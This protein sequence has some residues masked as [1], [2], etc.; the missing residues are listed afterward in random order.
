MGNHFKKIVNNKILQHIIFWITIVVFLSIPY[1]TKAGQC[2]Q[3]S[4]EIL[5]LTPAQI[6]FVYVLIYLLIP[7]FLIKKKYVLFFVSFILT[8]AAALMI[9]RMIQFYITS[10]IFYADTKDG[11]EFW[12]FL[13]FFYGLISIYVVAGIAATIKLV[14]QTLIS[15]KQNQLLVQQKL[16]AE[17]KL[18]KSQIHPHFLFNTLNNLYALALDNSE[19]SAKGIL[20]LSGLLHYMLYDCNA[21][22]VM[23]KREI[24]QI[25]DY[26]SLE[27]L[28]Y[29]N[30]LEVEF[31]IVGKTDNKMIPPMI[32]L[33]FVENAFK[34]GTSKHLQKASIYINLSAENHRLHLIVKNSKSPV[35]SN[36][37]SGYTKGIG[38]RNVR[39]RLELLYP[40]NHT[41]DIKDEENKFTIYLDIDFKESF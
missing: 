28:R 31:D 2:F 40:D 9:L 12:A 8:T 1:C 4:M 34:H 37:E 29:S 36:D 39:R 17:L 18:L 33:P 3:L 20:K 19:K 11:W 21:P 7:K 24:Q 22:L 23:L 38:L 27:K 26:I 15:N 32:I 41:L 35:I 14:R 13:Y 6:F 30:R 10:K 16:E 25:E 5:L